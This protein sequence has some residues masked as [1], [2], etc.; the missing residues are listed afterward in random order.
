MLRGIE[1]KDKQES[2][3]PIAR[4]KSLQTIFA[5]ST[6]RH[7]LIFTKLSARHEPAGD[8][9]LSTN[10]RLRI[11]KTG[12]DFVG[13][14]RRS[15]YYLF[16]FF[17][18]FTFQ[19]MSLRLYI[20]KLNSVFVS[21]LDH[22]Q[23]GKDFSSR[24]F[25]FFFELFAAAAAGCRKNRFSCIAGEAKISSNFFPICPLCNSLLLFT[26]VHAVKVEK[27]FLTSYKTFA[28]R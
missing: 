7:A 25:F 21:S 19:D 11:G 3:F 17:S 5:L 9:A 27:V 6:A 14:V 15:F 26:I 16:L 20:R 23:N 1:G 18:S 12:R 13:G 28:N 24:W 2:F 4:R 22:R 8:C 10:Q